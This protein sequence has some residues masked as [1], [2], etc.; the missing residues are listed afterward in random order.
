LADRKAL[1]DHGRPITTDSY[2][3][4]S[5]GPV[6]AN[7]LERATG[8][9]VSNEHSFW[10]NH[11]TPASASSSGHEVSLTH[12]ADEGELPLV[13]TEILDQVFKRYRSENLGHLLAALPECQGRQCAIEI[14]DI[15]RAGK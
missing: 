9:A 8:A 12:G 6:L 4:T 3:M 11:I 2:L 14:A 10:S 7:L 5:R 1:L 13:Q 15:L